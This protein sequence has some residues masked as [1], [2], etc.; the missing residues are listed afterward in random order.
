MRERSIMFD[1]VLDLPQS[2]SGKVVEM[3]SLI[4]SLFSRMR[5][6]YKDSIRKSLF[7][8][9]IR[10]STKQKKTPLL[11]IFWAVS[12]V[13]HLW[14]TDCHYNVWETPFSIKP[15]FT[16]LFLQYFG[17]CATLNILFFRGILQLFLWY[18]TELDTAGKV[19]RVLPIL[20]NSLRYLECCTCL[21][22]HWAFWLQ[23]SDCW[24]GKKQV[25]IL[26]NP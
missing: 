2:Q 26:H 10:E 13:E 5:T 14:K 19:K 4:W 6:E 8:A 7:S 23:H 22:V 3:R 17:K 20:A 16:K 1:V 11:D 18:L 24:E 12:S 15:Y 9:Q 21:F 25:R